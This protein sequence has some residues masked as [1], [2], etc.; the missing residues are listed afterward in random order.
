[1]SMLLGRFE[2]S[3][4]LAVYHLRGSGYAVS[5][6]DELGQRTG[7]SVS[8]G[9]VYATADRLEKKGLVSSKLGEA[10]PERGGKQKRLYQ[11]TGAG[12]KILAE[13]QRVDAQ[14]WAGARPAGAPA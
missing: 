6:A 3:V 7:K 5:I 10:T 9:A 13:I 2:Q 4:L 14:M 8:F 1:M 11:V 12:I